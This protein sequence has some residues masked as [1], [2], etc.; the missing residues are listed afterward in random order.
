M[1]DWMKRMLS[2]NSEPARFEPRTHLERLL[3]NAADDPASRPD[4]YRALL[5]SKVCV[6]GWIGDRQPDENEEDEFV[7]QG[8]EQLSIQHA[9]HEGREVIPIFT[10]E[11]RVAAYAPGSTYVALLARDLLEMTGPQELLLNPG[12]PYG[13]HFTADEVRGLLDGSLFQP[14]ETWVAQKP[15]QMLIGKPARYPDKFVA[16]L[17]TLFASRRNVRRAYLALIHIPSRNEA[18]N[19][20]LAIDV[21]GDLGPVAADCGIVARETLEPGEFTDIATPS[22]APDY[23]ASDTPIYSRD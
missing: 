23:F 20:L 4:F 15:E 1:L 14:Q 8:G 19:L 5:D 3:V 2:R 21:E 9:Q 6:I 22:I 18:P 11:E 12:S 16:A 17:Q 7:A 10:S 13:K